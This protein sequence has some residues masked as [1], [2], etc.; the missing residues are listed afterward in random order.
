MNAPISKHLAY[1]CPMPL[2]NNNMYDPV[3]ECEQ[4]RA[5]PGAA[6][7]TPLSFIHSVRHSV[8]VCENTFMAPPCPYGWKWC[9]QS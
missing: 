6:L 8:M 3:S 7:Q 2:Q 4:T 5:K 9:L 1:E